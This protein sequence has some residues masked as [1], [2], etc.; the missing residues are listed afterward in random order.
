MNELIAHTEPDAN[1]PSKNQEIYGVRLN[2]SWDGE[3]TN[4]PKK[5]PIHVEQH[6][7]H[8]SIPDMK[9]NNPENSKSEFP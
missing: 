2:S 3:Y 6:I 9:L 4:V 7:I 5:K 8:E 1:N